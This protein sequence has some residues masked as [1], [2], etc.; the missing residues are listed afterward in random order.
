LNND[1]TAPVADGTDRPHQGRHVKGLIEAFAAFSAMIAVATS[2]TAQPVLEYFSIWREETFAFVDTQRI[3][4]MH[5]VLTQGGAG[6]VL[7]FHDHVVSSSSDAQNSP[8]V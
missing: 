2:L 8:P 7:A 3:T 1:E 4:K 6:T 5:S